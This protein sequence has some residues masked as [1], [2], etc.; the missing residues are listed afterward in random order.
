MKLEFN[1]R[2]KLLVALAIGAATSISAPLHA[3]GARRKAPPAPVRPARQEPQPARQEQQPV[4]QE[5]QREREKASPEDLKAQAER[6]RIEK[7]RIEQ[8]RKEAQE[9]RAAAPPMRIEERREI[10]KKAAHFEANYRSRVARINRLI[11]IYKAKGDDAHVAQ[12]EQMRQKLEVRREHAMEGFRHDLG[13]SGFQHVQ[14]QLNGPARKPKSEPPKDK[15][16]GG[17]GGD[18]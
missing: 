11:G 16:P 7:A 14:G 17:T 9:G 4:R 3:D 2:T 6:D 13:D 12:L 18:R 1:G 8:R 15:P 10:A 5:P